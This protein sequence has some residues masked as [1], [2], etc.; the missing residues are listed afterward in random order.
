MWTSNQD[1]HRHRKGRNGSVLAQ[2]AIPEDSGVATNGTSSTRASSAMSNVSHA[3]NVS[4]APR[5]E[6]NVSSN[7]GVGGVGGDKRRK[8]ES[9]MEAVSMGS[10]DERASIA[11][12][13]SSVTSEPIDL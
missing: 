7:P 3:S 9:Y 11:S 1:R 2:D 12:S 5:R 8:R 13:N 6:V 10:L 4:G